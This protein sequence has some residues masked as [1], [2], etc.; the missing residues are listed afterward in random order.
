MELFP[1]HAKV[2]RLCARNRVR[3]S[4]TGTPPASAAL[5]GHQMLKELIR[6][7]LLPEELEAVFASSPKRVGS[8]D[9][10]RWGYNSETSQLALGVA[11]KIYDSYFHT[12]AYG[13]ENVPPCGRV[14]I[15]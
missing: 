15:I 10:D 9:Y 13:L 12:E 14:L 1:C 8:L 7:Y 11:K 2:N 5:L 6:R 3:A 4:V